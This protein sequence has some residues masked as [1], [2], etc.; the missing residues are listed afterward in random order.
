MSTAIPVAA[1]K[2]VCN[3]F[4]S[5]PWTRRVTRAMVA[6]QLEAGNFYARP[7]DGN[8][9]VAPELHAGRIAYFVKHGWKDA[10]GI[11][12]GV[13][14]MGCHVRWPVQDGNHRLAAAIYR[15]DKSILADVD[16]SVN[17]AAELLGVQI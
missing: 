7:L 8:P 2:R 11:D 17:Y 5:T 13:P 12:V 4:R 1:I 10:I 16:G 6:K 14:S 15:D 9:D 3:P